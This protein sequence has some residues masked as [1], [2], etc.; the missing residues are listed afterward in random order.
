VT[1]LDAARDYRRAYREHEEASRG[2]VIVFRS[3]DPA[4]LRYLATKAARDAAH[5]RLTAA[6]LAVDLAEHATNGA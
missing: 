5:D 6:A 4:Y 3:D 2:L 1:L